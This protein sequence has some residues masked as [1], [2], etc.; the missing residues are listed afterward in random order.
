MTRKLPSFF[1]LHKQ[2]T[3]TCR[4]SASLYLTSH[5]TSAASNCFLCIS[6]FRS[7]YLD[8]FFS[9][10]FFFRSFISRI[11]FRRF[12]FHRIHATPDNLI[13]HRLAQSLILAKE[14]KTGAK[15]P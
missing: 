10:S 14:I 11:L 3:Q 6:F 13:P 5:F 9:Y 15:I 8:S 7:L 1:E 4:D 12:S 2:Q